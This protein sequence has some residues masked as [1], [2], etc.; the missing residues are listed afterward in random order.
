MTEYAFAN[1]GKIIGKITDLTNDVS[2]SVSA[3]LKLASGEII[4]GNYR[5]FTTNPSNDNDEDS[6]D[7]LYII[8]TDI[9]TTSFSIKENIIINSGI[10][11]IEVGICYS[12]SPSPTID[13]ENSKC[14]NTTEIAQKNDGYIEKVLV[15]NLDP[16]TT[17]YV[18]GYWIFEGNGESNDASYSD[19]I[20]VTTEKEK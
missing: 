13:G 6:P 16:N 19:E 14:I 20:I 12:K 9:Q 15:E 4:Y 5:N 10:F 18:R 11:P 7:S 2:Y 8:N 1:Q 17:Y 3:F